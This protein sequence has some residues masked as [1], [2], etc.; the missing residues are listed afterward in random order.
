MEKTDKELFFEFI[1]LKG[2]KRIGKENNER[3]ISRLKHEFDRMV[4]KNFINYFLC[5][6]DFV[7]EAKEN[8]IMVGPG[9]GSCGGS[10]ASYCLNITEIDPIEHELLF[11]RFLSS[12]R[13]DTPDSDLDFQDNRR[14]E[15]FSYLENAYGKNHCAKIATYAKFHPKG[16]L[17]DLGRIFDIPSSEINKVCNLMLS[18]SGGDARASLS[19]Q[20]SFVEFKEAQEFQKKYPLVAEIAMKLEGTIRH[21]SSHAAGIVVSEK[22]ISFY[23]PINKIGGVICVEWEKALTEEINLIKFDIL[24]LKNLTIIKDAITDV[25]DCLPRTFEDPNVY[26]KIFKPANT[27]GIFQFNTVGMTK[28]ISDLDIS[29]FSDLYDAACI[30]RPAALHTGTASVYKNRKLGKEQTIYLHPALEKITRKTKGCILYQEQV[31]QIMNSIGNFSWSTA[32][33]ARK[34]ITKSKGKDAFNKMRKEF[35]ANAQKL[36]SMT[37]EEAEKIYDYVCMFGSYSFNKSHSCEYSIISYWCAWLKLYYPQAFYKSLLKYELD[38]AEIKNIIQDAAKNNIFI[39]FPDINKSSFSYEILDNKIYAG[40]SSINGVGEKIAEKI[41]LN[42]PYVDFQD[43][44]KRCKISDKLL[45]GLIVADAFR[46][47]NIN[48][49]SEYFEDNF[50]EDFTDVEQA[51]LVYEYTSLTPKINIKKS[52]DFGNFNFIDIKDLKEHDKKQVFLRGIIT[53]VLKKDKILRYDEKH[54]HKFEKRLLYLNLSDDTGNVACQVGPET[55]EKYQSLIEKIKKHPV[56]VYGKAI[57]GG[58]RIVVDMLEIVDGDKIT[59]EL[60][61]VFKQTHFLNNNEA[62]IVSAHPQVSKAGKSYYRVVLSTGLEGLCFR[63]TEKLFP[64]L[65]VEYWQN[66]EPFINLKIIKEEKKL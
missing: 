12:I 7:R 43:F 64:G 54:V 27:V 14:D 37:S 49:K 52:F 17:R 33:Q 26:E 59:T 15:I 29:C 8:G 56:I 23:A 60:R 66:Q 45:K 44:K 31:M 36:H 61:E 65:L 28:Y 58:N 9:R 19:C 57:A 40:L 41:I 1:L 10:L 24:G 35:V 62:Y 30:Y 55:F 39:E 32:E 20:D 53:D 38:S 34:I 5:T 42:R 51:Q 63:F 16:V 50:A 46:D 22:D 4:E 48:K 3:Y 47:F 11:L 25:K 21:K 2:L 18:R 6:W 13:F